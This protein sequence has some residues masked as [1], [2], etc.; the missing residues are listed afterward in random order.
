MTPK[1]PV[2]I[3]TQTSSPAMSRVVTL[4]SMEQ[5]LCAS[6]HSPEGDGAT[7]LE[8]PPSASTRLAICLTYLLK[9][10]SQ[11]SLAGITRPIHLRVERRRCFFGNISALSLT[12]IVSWN[13]PTIPSGRSTVKFQLSLEMLLGTPS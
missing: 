5:F 4:A 1:P 2:S 9:T 10:G 12:D 11:R 6:L 13:E 3:P 8:S 7:I